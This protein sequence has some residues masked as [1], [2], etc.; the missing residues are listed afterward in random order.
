M[1]GRSEAVN[2]RRGDGGDPAPGGGGTPGEAGR[3]VAE[4]L[5]LLAGLTIVVV[6]LRSVVA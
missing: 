1:T 5:P 3:S 6:A 2:D 4:P